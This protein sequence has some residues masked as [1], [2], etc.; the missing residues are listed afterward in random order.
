MMSNQNYNTTYEIKNIDLVSLAQ[1]HGIE[2]KK[3][4]PDMLLAAL[5]IQ[6]KLVRFLFIQ[7]TV[8]IALA[9]E[10]SVMPPLL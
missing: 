10:H 3:V 1:S 9:A 6:K 5:S 4:V 7:T 8:S 2:L